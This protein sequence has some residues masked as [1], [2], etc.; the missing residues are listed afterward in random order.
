M[1]QLVERSSIEQQYV[2]DN[3]TGLNSCLFVMSFFVVISL[4]LITEIC[5]HHK[6][7]Y[8]IDA[9]VDHKV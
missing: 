2:H 6:Y 5:L 9:W 7:N 3:Y 4:L 1:P 8:V